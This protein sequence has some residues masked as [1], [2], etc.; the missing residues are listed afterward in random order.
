MLQTPRVRR[1]GRGTGA[2]RGAEG[3]LGMRARTFA[4]SMKAQPPA[5]R[6]DDRVN[7]LVQV[8][9]VGRLP[10]AGRSRWAGRVRGRLQGKPH[11]EGCRPCVVYREVTRLHALSEDGPLDG[12]AADLWE[13]E[14]GKCRD[15]EG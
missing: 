12:P 3:R 1:E 2:R 15:R 9:T 13:H 11:P 14:R 10:T 7:P 4:W 5:K 8:G 6:G